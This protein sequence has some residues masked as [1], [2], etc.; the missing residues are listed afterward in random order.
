MK[1]ET[2]ASDCVLWAILSTQWR[3]EDTDETQVTNGQQQS[4]KVQELEEEM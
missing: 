2:T 4:W 1:R 3:S